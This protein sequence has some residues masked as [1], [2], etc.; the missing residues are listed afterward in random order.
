MWMLLKGKI[1]TA[2]NLKRKGYEGPSCCA[3]C[4][5]SGENIQHLFVGF[6][7]ARACWKGLVSPLEVSIL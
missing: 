1:L 2:D 4:Q 3:M 6:P 5:R 7:F